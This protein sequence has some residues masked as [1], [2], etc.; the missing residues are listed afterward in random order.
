MGSSSRVRNR[1][2]WVTTGCGCQRPA[3]TRSPCCPSSPMPPPRWSWAQ[4]S[5]WASPATR[6]PL[7]YS[8]NDIQMLSQG[9][10]ILGLGSQIRPHITRRFS[11]E[12]SKPAARMREMIQAIKAIWNCWNNGEKLNFRGGLLRAHADDA[13][14][15]PRREPLRS[16]PAGAGRRGP[17]DDRGGRRDVRHLPLPR[18]HHREVPAR[19]DH[20]GDRAGRCAGRS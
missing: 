19:G 11:M 3:T 9:R 16:A 10:F 20:P 13:V 7:A 12:W 14:L 5:W 17:A 18:I 6:C 2:R 8:A 15:R 1:K 4:A